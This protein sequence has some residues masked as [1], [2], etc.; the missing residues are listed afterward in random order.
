MG[1]GMVTLVRMAMTQVQV[2]W[3]E[4]ILKSPSATRSNHV[5]GVCKILL[6]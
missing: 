5:G 1:M 4:E 6:S 2:L 3:W